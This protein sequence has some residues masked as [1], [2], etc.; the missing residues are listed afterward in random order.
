MNKQLVGILLTLLNH[1]EPVVLP[2]EP[3]PPPP[4][5][6][7]KETVVCFGDSIT[8]GYKAIGYPVY[9][10][11]M[12]SSSLNVVNAGLGGEDT[13]RGVA[14][15]K[16]VLA[17]NRPKY[18]VIMEGANDVVEGISP[19]TTTY[20]LNNMALQVKRA[21]GIPIMST[22]TPNTARRSY[23]PENYNPSIIQM[24]YKG[25]FTL[26]NTYSR[27]ASSWRSI[28]FDG[29]HPNDTGSKMIAEGFA[30][31]LTKVQGK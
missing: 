25:R 1:T 11:S 16:K 4:P 26:V 20:D 12:K 28:T 3:P 29:I 14:R 15:M 6:A 24:A 10:Q 19:S 13:Y 23:V 9:L 7:S 21:G 22:I 2:P 30:E 8:A 27:M 17:A 18:V 5:L 31:A